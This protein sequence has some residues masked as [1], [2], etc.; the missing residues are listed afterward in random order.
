MFHHTCNIT[1]AI[2]S[3]WSINIRTPAMTTITP[4]AISDHLPQHTHNIPHLQRSR[5]WRALI[6]TQAF[7]KHEDR[8]H[9]SPPSTLVLSVVVLLLFL[10]CVVNIRIFFIVHLTFCLPFA[11]V[12]PVEWV[13]RLFFLFRHFFTCFILRVPVTSTSRGSNCSCT[14]CIYRSFYIRESNCSGKTP[15]LEK[16]IYRKFLRRISSYLK[17]RSIDPNLFA[18]C[19]HALRL[20]RN[21]G[22]VLRTMISFSS[23][24]YNQGSLITQASFFISHFLE[25]FNFPSS[26]FPPDTASVRANNGQLSPTSLTTD[27]R[28]GLRV[29]LGMREI[30]KKRNCW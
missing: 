26:I 2:T 10:A 24:D 23:F 7:S 30:R 6:N 4:L 13:V 16:K 29:T 15:S 22:N 8:R 21:P 18:L 5:Y 25:S 20:F 27:N 28:L 19:K 17:F 3:T 9:G 12:T 14:L 1:P 11:V